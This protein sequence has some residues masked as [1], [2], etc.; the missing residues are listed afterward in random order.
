VIDDREAHDEGKAFY[1]RLAFKEGGKKILLL[2]IA[3]WQ[4]VRF[5]S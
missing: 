2:S 1:S 3:D 5:T 4:T